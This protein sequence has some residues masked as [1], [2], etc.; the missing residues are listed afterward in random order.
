MASVRAVF[1]W[2]SLLDHDFYAPVARIHHDKKMHMIFP[3]YL[4]RTRE[5]FKMI[6]PPD[7]SHGDDDATRSLC[8]EER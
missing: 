7:F 4:V 1:G 8:P 2:G 5:G 3:L 6:P